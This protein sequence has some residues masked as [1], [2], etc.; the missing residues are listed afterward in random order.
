MNTFMHTHHM[1]GIIYIIP[2]P[3]GNLGD[4][5]YRAI[6]VLKSVNL[7]ATENTKY[8][9]VLLNKFNIKNKLFLLH[10]HNEHQKTKLLLAYLQNG[11]NIALVCRAGTPL[12]NDPGYPLV[13]QCRR[14]NIK[15]VPL[16]GACAAITALT[17]SGLSTNRFCYEGFL[18]SKIKSRLNILHKLIHEPRTMIFYESKH[19]LLATLR[20]IIDTFG[21]ERY[22]VLAREITKIW[23]SIHGASASNLLNW[24]QENQQ[25]RKGEMVLVIEGFQASNIEITYYHALNTFQL[26]NPELSLKKA[27][28]ITSKIHGISKNKLYRYALNEDK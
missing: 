22:V 14:M 26:L 23:E 18:P 19:R 24:L 20:D 13:S 28:E 10:S 21:S 8:T 25:R 1:T 17:A 5:T 6:N 27:V 4:I 2:T 16:P 12:I 11:Q 9:K 7:I 15:V 3:I